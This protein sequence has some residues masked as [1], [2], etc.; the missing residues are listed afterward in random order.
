MTGSPFGGYTVTHVLDCLAAPTK[1]RVIAEAERDVGDIF[2]YLNALLRNASYAAEA[3]ILVVKRGHRLVTL[4]PHLAL[5]AKIDGPEDVQFTLAWLRDIIND[6]YARRADIEPCYD[7]R[8]IVGFLEVYRLLP[9]D[10]CRSC[11]EATC[12]AFAVG[13]TEGRHHPDQCP[14]LDEAHRGR[15]RALVAE[16]LSAE[17]A[18]MAKASA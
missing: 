2:P 8:R 9:G 18:D 4:Y 1:L 15:L 12:L 7:R 14:R 11:G 5:M 6:A 10:N 16:D 17:P 3:N 13:V